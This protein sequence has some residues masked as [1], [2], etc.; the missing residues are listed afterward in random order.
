VGR[1]RVSG[2]TSPQF[3]PVC[4]DVSVSSFFSAFSSIF[5]C[6]EEERQGK[7]A[8]SSVRGGCSRCLQSFLKYHSVVSILKEEHIL[9]LPTQLLQPVN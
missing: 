5:S 9:D 2:R 3:S 6:F 7:P 8:G 1:R 4:F